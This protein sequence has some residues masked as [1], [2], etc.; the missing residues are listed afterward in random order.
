MHDVAKS[1]KARAN[2]VQS[3]INKASKDLNDQRCIQ[4]VK[5]ITNEHVFYNKFVVL[6][7]IRNSL[8]ELLTRA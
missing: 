1:E 8:Y 4:H 7:W 2:I 6:S 3:N 5:S